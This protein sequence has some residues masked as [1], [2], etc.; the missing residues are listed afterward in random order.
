MVACSAGLG[1][2]RRASGPARRRRVCRRAATDPVSSPA[3][4]SKSDPARPGS[5]GGSGAI[6][7]PRSRPGCQPRSDPAAVVQEGPAQHRRA[8]RPRRA[9][10]RRQSGDDEAGHQLKLLLKSLPTRVRQVGTTGSIRYQGSGSSTR[11]PRCASVSIA[12]SGSLSRPRGRRQP[13]S[14][15]MP[16]SRSYRHASCRSTSIGSARERSPRWHSS[17]RTGLR[18]RVFCRPTSVWRRPEL[19]PFRQRAGP[20]VPLASLPPAVHAAVG[21][22]IAAF[23]VSGSVKVQDSPCCVGGTMGDKKSVQVTFNA[24]SPHGQVTEMK[25]GSGSSPPAAP[26]DGGGAG[27]SCV[28]RREHAGHAH[29]VV[30]V[31]GGGPVPRR[32]WQPVDG[33]V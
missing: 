26:I 27:G 4:V 1:S 21:A 30:D 7:K 32:G 23:P 22:R 31:R 2:P 19:V 15:Q 25:L 3:A 20:S 10:D 11:S 16:G 18:S 14:F 9:K 24:S 28:S 6:P 13:V 29:R 5:G 17:G 33:P 8:D 12:G